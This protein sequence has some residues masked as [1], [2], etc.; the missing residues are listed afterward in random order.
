MNKVWSRRAIYGSFEAQHFLAEGVAALLEPATVLDGTEE[1]AALSSGLALG[2]TAAALGTAAGGHGERGEGVAG[3]EEGD[4]LG[5]AV[6][7]GVAALLLGHDVVEALLGGGEERFLAQ[8]VVG[9]VG[10]GWAG[11][12]L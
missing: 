5:V 3:G 10:A 8:R 7:D 2:A 11:S 9:Y 1:D 12:A 4:E 6:A